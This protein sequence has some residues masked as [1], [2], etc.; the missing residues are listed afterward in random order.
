[1][2]AG[3]STP[4]AELLSLRYSRAAS[5]TCCCSDLLYAVGPAQGVFNRSPDSKCSTKYVGQTELAVD[6]VYIAGNQL[7]ARTLNPVFRYTVFEELVQCCIQRLFSGFDVDA[8]CRC[9]T[10]AYFAAVQ[11]VAIVP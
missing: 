11:R 1:M 4:V 8:W 5:L 9:K 3:T 2:G 10:D 6:G 7:V